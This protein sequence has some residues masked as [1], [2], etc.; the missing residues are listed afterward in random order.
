MTTTAYLME[1][2]LMTITMEFLTPIRNLLQDVS[3]AKNNPHG[4][5]IT[6]ELLTGQTMTGMA[7]E[8]ATLLNYK[9][10]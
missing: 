7:M 3:G 9:F 1:K 5:T 4:I 10:P 6:M 2:T 8:S